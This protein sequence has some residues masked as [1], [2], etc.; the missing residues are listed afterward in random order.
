MTASGVKFAERMMRLAR[1]VAPRRRRPRREIPKN[2]RPVG[3]RL[4]VGRGYGRARPRE[5]SWKEVA[6]IPVWSLVLYALWSL[7]NYA[8]WGWW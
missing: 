2:E 1:T 3:P 4:E 7:W 6:E 8:I 5:E